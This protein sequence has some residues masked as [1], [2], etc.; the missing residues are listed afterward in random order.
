MPSSVNANDSLRAFIAAPSGGFVAG[1]LLVAVKTVTQGAERHTVCRFQEWAATH[2]SV[3]FQTLGHTQSGTDAG[4]WEPDGE[5]NKQDEWQ[6]WLLHRPADGAPRWYRLLDGEEQWSTDDNALHA[7]GSDLNWFSLFAAHDGGEQCDQVYIG[8]VLYRTGDVSL[9]DMLDETRTR[10]IAHASGVVYYDPCD[11][12]DT[13][14]TNAAPEGDDR[15]GNATINGVGTTVEDEPAFADDS[16]IGE[17]LEAAKIVVTGHSL[18]DDVEPNVAVLAGALSFDYEKHS[19]PGSPISAR[20]KGDGEHPGDPPW[21]GYFDPNANNKDGNG[22]NM[23]TH[24]RAPGAPYT[25]LVIAERHDLLG[26]LR[27]EA[28]VRYLRHFYE[29]TRTGSPECQGYIYSTWLDFNPSN[30][31]D[32]ITYAKANDLAHAAV[33][34]RINASLALE[35]RQDRLI[36]LPASGAL[37][38][39]VERATE[40]D[41]PGITGDNNAETLATLFSDNVHPTEVG[42]YFLACVVFGA[43]YRRDPRGLDR[44]Q[45]VTATQAQSL[46]AIAW[47]VLRSTYA[48]S[49]LGPQLSAED[50]QQAIVD[51]VPVYAAVY[52]DVTQFSVDVEQEQAFFG[53]TASDMHFDP[54]TDA[55]VWFAPPPRATRRRRGS[56]SLSTSLGIG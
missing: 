19:I 14:G 20:T 47:H 53:G 27:W 48:G 46:Q 21:N 22:L 49:P 23:I 40:D 39:L 15:F 30:L 3:F 41:V 45:G 33:A 50:A 26:A 10:G 44:P 17:P 9:E 2:T 1:A 7:A 4:T 43:V 37:A 51:F 52:N 36:L 12:A 18:T 28:T 25:D 32:W 35:E 42:R 16:N 24:L 31:A 55:E 11:D 5:G 34:S 56:F 13:F 54:E 8:K 38:E 6:W 29:L